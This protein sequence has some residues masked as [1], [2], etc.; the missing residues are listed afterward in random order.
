MLPN[1]LLCLSILL[2]QTSKTDHNAL[3]IYAIYNLKL[4]KT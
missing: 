4:I 1:F 3:D 2:L